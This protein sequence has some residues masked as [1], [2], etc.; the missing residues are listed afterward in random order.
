M[1]KIEKSVFFES[2]RWKYHRAS[3]KGK[4]E[5]LDEVCERLG[6]H[7]KHATRLLQQKNVGRK[8]KP[9]KR[10]RKSKYDCPEFLRA[11]RKLW[12]ESE[13]KG[14]RLL[15]AS[16]PEWLPFFEANFW[17]L[18]SEVEEKL[19]EV[20]HATMERKLRGV[21]ASFGK[22]K[23]GTKP[24]NLL[25]KEIPISTTCWDTKIP[26]FVEADTVAHCGGSLMGNF[27]WSLTLTDIATTWTEIRATWN[28]GA[29]GV[30]TRIR[31]IESH[32]PFELLGFDCDNGSEFL[33]HH[34]V[35]YFA[36]EHPRKGTI[37]F[38][39][40]RPYHKNDNAHV[41]QKN[42]THA[43]Q[44]LGYDRLEFEQ[45]VAPIND[46]CANEFSLFRN[47][48][49]PTFKLCNKIMVKTR[50]KRI[51]GD[52]VTPY[53]R[54]LDSPDVSDDTKQALRE[55]HRTLDPFKLRRKIER[56]L[57]NIDSLHK[58]LKMS[59]AKAHSA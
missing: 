16:L 20:S 41:E 45:L 25:R 4:G 35:N 11:L 23:S 2:L 39:R 32:L 59:Q 3:K 46:L 47:H 29:H 24:G 42:W 50:Y 10:G 58:K 15:K 52:P 54:V 8:P 48:F 13:F 55:V 12:V 56:K 49:V 22:G 9:K 7:R 43:R 18:S 57:K 53:K 37:Y 40:S 44:L 30:L 14:A 28:K 19:L 27:I 51:Y 31:D 36:H 1:H 33:N 6:W 34:L 17:K 26:G 21:R 38:T 5:I